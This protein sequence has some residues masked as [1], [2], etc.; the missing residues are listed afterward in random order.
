MPLIANG[1]LM[2]RLATRLLVKKNRVLTLR[3]N[4]K[5]KVRSLHL[6]N[7]AM[8]GFKGIVVFQIKGWLCD[9]SWL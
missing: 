3:A 2:D 7:I 4:V 9:S 1:V 8:F 5:L 6:H